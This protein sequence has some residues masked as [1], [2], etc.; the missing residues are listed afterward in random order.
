[1][2]VVPKSVQAGVRS[3]FAGDKRVGR[4]AKS[5]FGRGLK[6]RGRLL[7]QAGGHAKLTGGHKK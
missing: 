1:M 2:R 7:L 5:A 3:K 4:R 6:V